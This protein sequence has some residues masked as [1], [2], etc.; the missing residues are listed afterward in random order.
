MT[1]PRFSPRAPRGGGGGAPRP[2]PQ[3]PAG[4]TPSSTPRSVLRRPPVQPQRAPAARPVALPAAPPRLAIGGG[5]VRMP[6]PPHQRGRWRLPIGPL[7][8]ALVLVGLFCVGLGVGHATG[9]DLSSAF[10]GEDKPPPREFPVLDPS[11][12]LAIAIP[13]IGVKA[14]VRKV[15]LAADGSVAVPP[16]ERHNQA[17][18]FERGPTPGQFGPAMIVGHAD[19][20]DGP[21]IFHNLTLLK[22]GARVEVTRSDRTVAVFEVNSIEH[23]DKDRLPADRVY[24]DYSRPSLRLVTCSGRW[25]G[26]GIGYSDNTVVFASLV[27]SRDA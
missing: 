3:I 9:I 12:P 11:R 1:G 21:S 14:P 22:P 20:R 24:G 13:S 16:L 4:R 5:R 15:G 23:F 17:G 8:I 19:T 7:A 18:W 25:E 10:D 27:D 26:E 6:A 2:G